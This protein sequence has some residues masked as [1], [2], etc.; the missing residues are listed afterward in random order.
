MAFVLVGKRKKKL[1]NLSGI[2]KKKKNQKTLA[3]STVTSI[4]AFS[5]IDKELGLISAKKPSGCAYRVYYCY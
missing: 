5:I 2:R 3:L 4:N 1:A